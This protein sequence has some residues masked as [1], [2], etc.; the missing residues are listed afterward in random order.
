LLRS[1]ASIIWF[2]VAGI[3]VSCGVGGGGI[4][5]PMGMILLR[6]PPKPSAGLSQACI[7]G[8]GIG[9]LFINARKHHPDRHIRDTKGLPSEKGLGKIVPY[10]TNMTHTQIEADRKRYLQ[11]GDGHRKFYTRPVIDYDL[12]LLMAPMELAGAVFGVTVQRVLPD[13]LFLSFAVVV[14]GFTCYKTFK[15]VWAFSLLLLSVPFG[16]LIHSSHC[17]IVSTKTCIDW[18]KNTSKKLPKPQ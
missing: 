13:W 11:G 7:F 17:L 18:K 5:V 15:K 10:E 14:L 9:G 8:A 4:Y 3:A 12:L 1:A 2:L 16:Q 6:F